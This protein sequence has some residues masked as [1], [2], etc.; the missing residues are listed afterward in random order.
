MRS[1]ASRQEVLSAAKS[2]PD[3]GNDEVRLS[4]LQGKVAKRMEE[5]ERAEW[6]FKERLDREETEA[7]KEIGEIEKKL[8]KVR[9]D[10][11]GLTEGLKKSSK[12]SA[13]KKI[14][15]SQQAR[16]LAETMVDEKN[17]K[18]QMLE[19]LRDAV[20]RVIDRLNKLDPEEASFRDQLDDIQL[21][22]GSEVACYRQSL[23]IYA[24]RSRIVE[25]ARNCDVTILVAETG[26]G[27]SSQVP[28]YLHLDHYVA[29]G[30]SIV[31]T[32]PR[33]VAASNLASYVSD[34]LGKSGG[35]Q[36]KLVS[37]DFG[38]KGDRVGVRAPSSIVFTTDNAL[39]QEWASDNLLS[40]YD[41]VIV[42]EAHERTLATDLLLSILK[43]TLVLRP[44]RIIITSA[45]IDPDTFRDYFKS[46]RV[47]V[48][49]V[50][51]K[52][53]PVALEWRSHR[54]QM[55]VK[56][57][58]L[59]GAV[60]KIVD[61]ITQPDYDG[62]SVL[63]FVATL[64]DTERGPRLLEERCEA[65]AGLFQ[66]FQVLPLHGRLQP[67]E[68]QKVFDVASCRL[69][70]I[71]FSTNVAETSVTVPGVTHVIDCG[72]AKERHFDPRSGASVLRLTAISKSSA[73]QRQGRAGRTA[74]G[75]CYRLY[76]EE[77]FETM[78]EA[79]EPE[80]QRLPLDQC[81]IMLFR[82]GVQSPLE[83]EFLDPPSPEAVRQ[84]LDTLAHLEAIQPIEEKKSS[85]TLTWVG[86][87]MSLFPMDPRLSRILVLALE[88]DHG[89]VRDAIVLCAIMSNGGNV[90]FRQ[91]SDEERNAAD[92][93]RIRFC[94]ERGDLVTML[95]VYNEWK[96]VDG[97]DR[98]RSMWC[99]DNY[100]NGKSMRIIETGIKEIKG[101][102]KH[103]LKASPEAL[104]EQKEGTPESLDRLFRMVTDS[105]FKNVA[106]YAGHPD[107][108]YV[109]KEGDKLL[110][111][112]PSSS[113][114]ALSGKPPT[115]V[116]FDSIF[117]T[118]RKHM[119]HVTAVDEDLSHL[120]ETFPQ[121]KLVK[122]LTIGPMGGFVQKAH[123]VGKKFVQ[124]KLLEKDI[125]ELINPDGMEV[126]QSEFTDFIKLEC[127]FKRG[128]LLAFSQEVFHPV[129]KTT[130]MVKL[131]AVLEEL[132]RD[133]MEVQ[134]E[135][136]AGLSLLIGE[137]GRV[138]TP[139]LPCDFIEIC[140][141]QPY[142]REA[143]KN[144][145][146]SHLPYRQRLVFL[147]DGRCI[148]A[149]RTPT[150]AECG[151]E[152]FV[153]N[154]A[155]LDLEENQVMKKRRNGRPGNAR[156]AVF[157]VMLQLR[158]RQRTNFGFIEFT[159]TSKASTYVSLSGGRGTRWQ[160]KISKKNAKQVF[161]TAML[162]SDTE[163]EV[164][165]TI[166]GIGID[167]EAALAK[168]T[169][170]C[171][172]G[173]A[174]AKAEITALEADMVRRLPGVM[175]TK[176][177]QLRIPPNCQPGHVFWKVFIEFSDVRAGRLAGQELDALKPSF[178]DGVRSYPFDKTE[179]TMNATL[180][181]FQE[182][183]QV[184]D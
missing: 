80:I 138:M 57:D 17:T 170:P 31:C 107:Q 120:F 49:G 175:Q 125:L 94:D 116:V 100:V 47:N 8:E 126:T 39:L 5:K 83:Y 171:A 88:S 1:S 159:T 66:K 178:S 112:H 167:E 109:T 105:F 132:K 93:R 98:A 110:V 141:K 102:A 151:Y 115:F 145:V 173:F 64:A 76:S 160:A 15:S 54:E 177:F 157:T 11:D 127:D 3:F 19:E 134:F 184:R 10:M 87:K 155:N 118:H 153:Q 140:I 56:E 23:P 27:K 24:F 9:R 121:L 147:E 108:G 36:K 172:K 78:R 154:L 71:V 114:S 35:K 37:A 25:S 7:R 117:T 106:M 20:A 131:D 148:V 42:D 81:L 50:P 60:K 176:K 77:D 90:F 43:K 165:K 44:L 158:R 152:E 103:A 101:I 137:G 136:E 2:I 82:L 122:K 123:F 128:T 119:M 59:P 135:K 45:T 53:Y 29:K 97:G 95:N 168:V 96:K 61:I 62:G 28:K 65:A 156:Q 67:E 38:Y 166:K 84:S 73:K 74:P 146:Q 30:S 72:V 63:V 40:K 32:Q 13:W 144:I 164:R 124:L 69:P 92:V 99:V 113:I 89:V 79:L 182:V 86:K 55:N 18:E 150:D 21:L 179:C 129:V 163:E 34:G 139:L 169:L 16:E 26:S 91:G 41:C 104:A 6:E 12:N 51:G 85:Y 161:L 162:P 111:L 58:Y 14:K 70:K 4:L 181:V 46:F 48:I 75:K 133:T 180:V 130:I 68:Q 183:F 52:L 149:F 174:S 33:K 142:V 22:F 143:I